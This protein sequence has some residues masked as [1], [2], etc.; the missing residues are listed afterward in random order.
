MVQYLHVAAG[1]PTKSTWLKSIL[2]RNY[3]TWL[4]ITVKDVNRHFPESEET[5]KGHMRNQLQR[6]RSTKSP[7]PG[8]D[9]PPD[10]KKQDVFINVYDPKRT[11]YTYQTDKF[12]HQSRR[13]NKYQMILHKIYGNS[14]WIEPMKNKIEGEKILD[15]RHTLGRIK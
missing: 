7:L 14:T 13:G 12:R 9:E 2:N 3:I 1:F 8:T 6:L 4:L 10:E 5:Q 15:R 11:K